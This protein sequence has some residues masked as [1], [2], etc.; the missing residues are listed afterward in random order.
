[1]SKED[2]KKCLEIGDTLYGI[3]NEI[4]TIENIDIHATLVDVENAKNKLLEMYNDKELW[5]LKY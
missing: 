1:M 5:K 2:S 4:Y 3:N